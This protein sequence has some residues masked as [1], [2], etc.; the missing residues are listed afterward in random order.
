MEGRFKS[1]TI[2]SGAGHAGLILW[3]MIGDWFFSPSEPTEP[4]SV[5]V[6]MVSPD[7]LA[8]LEAAAGKSSAEPAE[9]SETISSPDPVEPSVDE[10]VSEPTPE[11]TPQPEPEPQPQPE[12]T[13]EPAP[14][15]QPEPTPEPTPE[16]EPVISDPAPPDAVFAPEEQPIPTMST[17]PRPKPRP[18]ERV[19]PN[20]V[21]APEDTLTAERPQDQVTTSEEPTPE[22][23]RE[24]QQATTEVNSGDV[25]IT[26]A[27]QQDRDAEPLG[28]TTS[29]RPKPRP[30]RTAATPE[31][32]PTP[33]PAGET[34]DQRDA[35]IAAEVA[36]A[37]RAQ[38]EA[39]AK[40]RREAA[41]R[42]KAAADAEAAAIA[43]AV[44]AANTGSGGQGRAASGPPLSGGEMGDIAA[45]IGSKWNVGTLSADA[46]DA[47][48]VL[49]VT[50][51]ESGRPGSDMPLI[52][53]RGPSQQAIQAAYNAAR[54][55][56]ARAYQSGGIPLPPGKYETWKVLEFEFDGSGMRLR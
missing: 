40:A 5:Q 45:A 54:S 26:E 51:D 19:A 37:D 52:E 29:P 34:Q 9:S 10:P 32:T 31:P 25:L 4:M 20:P 1:G 30:N 28:P 16:P 35:R 15:P 6:T 8:D 53:S 42:E 22:P 39:E 14:Q 36:A 18:A 12:P 27:N 55:A 2:L 43:A 3:V 23:P 44:A 56:I 38:A 47:V 7:D 48:V 33:E 46:M 13:P 21:V 24:D 17:S 11:P 49:R 50:F 41:A